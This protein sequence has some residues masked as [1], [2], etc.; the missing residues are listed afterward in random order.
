[1]TKELVSVGSPDDKFAKQAG[2]AKEAFETAITNVSELAKLVQR[3]RT[4][5]AK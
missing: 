4:E 5:T 3:S 2:V 1:M